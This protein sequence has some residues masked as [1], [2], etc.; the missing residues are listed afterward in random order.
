[1]KK[2]KKS[3]IQAKLMKGGAAIGGGVV[4]NVLHNAAAKAL[5][6]DKAKFAPAAPIIG[7]LAFL[8]FT[9]EPHLEAMAYG[10]LGAGGAQGGDALGIGDSFTSGIYGPEDDIAKQADDLAAQMMEDLKNEQ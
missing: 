6:A 7:G 2:P 10:L 3:D 1:M 4:G 8:M 9:N 5:P